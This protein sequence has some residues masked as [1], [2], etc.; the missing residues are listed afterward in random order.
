VLGRDRVDDL[1]VPVP[2]ADGEDAREA[3]DVAPAAVVRQ[4]DPFAAD[5]DQRVGRERLL[6]LKSTIT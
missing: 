5:D 2:E 3:V 4:P 1:L 6:W